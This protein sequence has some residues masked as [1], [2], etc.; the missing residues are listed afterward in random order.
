MEW[1]LLP[2]A[3]KNICIARGF[4][5]LLT[6]KRDISEALANYTAGVG[7]KLRAQKSTCKRIQVFLHT[8][9][10]REE[11][12]QYYRA[13]TMDLPTATNHSGVLIRHAMKALDLIFKS[14]YN[15]NKCGFM[16]LD[17]QPETQIQQSLFD[18]GETDKQKAVMKA[19]DALNAG[20]GKDLVRLA[21]QG[22]DKAFKL[23]QAHLSRRYTTRM[24]EVLKIKI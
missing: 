12:R 10:H 6:R 8:N 9:A 16:A 5:K 22:Y 21:A 11:D 13:L 17:L 15:Y 2:P 1:E 23:R 14:E 19:V 4:G 20:L 7:E 18:P 24:D 3:K